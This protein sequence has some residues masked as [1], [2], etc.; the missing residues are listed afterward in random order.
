MH[1]LVV[2]AMVILLTLGPPR[3]E[4]P[5]GRGLPTSWVQ[6]R[7]AQ[8]SWVSPGV[9]VLGSPLPACSEA[10]GEYTAAPTQPNHRWT[11]RDSS[12]L[13][14]TGPWLCDAHGQR[15]GAFLCLRPFSRPSRKTGFHEGQVHSQLTLHDPPDPRLCRT[16]R[17]STCSPGLGSPRWPQ[18]TGRGS[19]ADPC[20]LLTL[21]SLPS[22]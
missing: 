2:H 7:R 5:G 6:S 17:G 1:I 15:P 4:Q 8:P 18:C 13:G 20:L 9:D 10:S 11:G 21:L 16:R 3:G 22:G 12:L 19:S 14:H